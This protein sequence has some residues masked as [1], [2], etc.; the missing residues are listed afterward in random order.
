[1]KHIHLGSWKTGTTLIQS[2]LRKNAKLLAADN[3]AFADQK[4]EAH[5]NSF[6]PHYRTY[7]KSLLSGREDST[8]LAKSIAAFDRLTPPG[9]RATI[10][11]WEPFL[12]HPLRSSRQHLYVAEAAARWFEPIV[13]KE[14]CLFTIYVR[15]Q[16]DF[17]EAMYAQEVRKARFL[18]GIDEF[19]N[20][21]CPSDLSWLPVVTPFINRFGTDRVR[22]IPFETIKTGADAFLDTFFAPLQ[23]PKLS[24]HIDHS[25]PSFSH[26]AIEIARLTYP[27]IDA[28]EIAKFEQFLV[29]NY[30]NLTHP[31]ADFLGSSR[32]KDIMKSCT[33][34]NKLLF[35]IAKI[36]GR[37]SQF[38][39][40]EK[41]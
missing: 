13:E 31:R 23:L 20:E 29:T 25:N 28:S 6:S 17:L 26:K 19:L 3:V 15:K 36:D 41:I 9:S 38:G 2:I 24:Y 34:A 14:E 32:R 10:H 5:V 27:I 8:A 30:S 33:Q 22:V 40:V 39:Y 11:S 37:P 1:M 12:G 21:L 7:L 4:S 16:A 35:E 18:K